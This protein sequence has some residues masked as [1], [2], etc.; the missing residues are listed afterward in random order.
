MFGEESTR[1][2]LIKDS[3]GVVTFFG[4]YQLGRLQRET[5]I[6]VALWGID[7][8]PHFLAQTLK[9]GANLQPVLRRKRFRCTFWWRL[10]MNLKWKPTQI[11]LEL[12]R[13]LFGPDRAEV[14]ERS[15]NVGPDIDDAIHKRGHRSTDYVV[16]TKIAKTLTPR[17]RERGINGAQAKACSPELSNRESTGGKNG[18][19]QFVCNFGIRFPVSNSNEFRS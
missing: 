9:P 5:R 10:R 2:V 12:S 8:K 3:D 18:L 6:N 4:A 16:A 11:S 14:T 1:N 15:N 13:R 7:W 19:G 17:R